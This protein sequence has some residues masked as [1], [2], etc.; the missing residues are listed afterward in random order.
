M[1]NK[2]GT[3]VSSLMATIK[4]VEEKEF[5]RGLAFDELKRLNINIEEFLRE[6][7]KEARR[8]RT[9]HSPLSLRVSWS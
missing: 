7:S 6:N 3:Y 2:L 4:D 5:V 9:L 8:E 1:D